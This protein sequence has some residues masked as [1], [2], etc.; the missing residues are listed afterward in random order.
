[1]AVGHECLQIECC[2]CDSQILSGFLT[3]NRVQALARALQIKRLLLPQLF[4]AFG[5]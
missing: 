3:M 4:E 1:M 5:S 2:H